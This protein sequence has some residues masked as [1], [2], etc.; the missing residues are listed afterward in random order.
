MKNGKTILEASLFLVLL[1]GLILP[2][3]V[4]EASDDYN[5]PAECDVGDW[6]DIIEVAAGSG[7]TVGL[8]SDG[9]VVAVGGNWEGQCDVGNWIDITRV[10]AG[11]LHTLGLKADDTVIAVGDNHNGQC[12]VE[13]WTDIKQVA[14]GF[15]HT[16]GLKADG[17]VVAAGENEYGQCD[18]EG[19]ADITQVAAGFYH[20]VGL[21]DDGTVVAV[22]A[23]YDGQC[24]VEGWTDIIQV[25][26]G[27]W[28][29]LGLK[30][31]G[32]VVAVGGAIP[33]GV[34]E[35]GCF[36][37][38]AAYGTPMAEDIQVL[39][40]FR[41]EYLLTSPLG[42]ALVGIYYRVS[43]PMAEFMA[44]HP[45]LKPVVRAGL[46][47]VAAMS[48]VVVNTTPAEKMAM[49]GSLVLVSVTLAVWAKRRRGRGPQYT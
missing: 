34:P 39:R 9:T 35:A 22:G 36:I 8:K 17:T 45:S 37:A 3:V 47:P 13:G 41:D 24:D 11:C 44:E 16:V 31:N 25:A 27:D 49:V 23:N 28:H 40:D 5:H 1:C 2:A 26:A 6:T 15:Y 19:W 30:S 4:A 10:A 32:T 7:H 46:L 20:T 48:T 38:T 42:Q 43:P 29:T 21:K 12:N 14:A 33:D 18:V